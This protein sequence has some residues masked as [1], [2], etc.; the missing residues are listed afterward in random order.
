MTNTIDSLIGKIPLDSELI[1][2]GECIERIIDHRG[3]TPL[4]LGSDWKNS[5]IPAI[6]AKN[7]HGGK[8][9]NINDL[10]FVDEPTY[11]KWMGD[12]DV[13]YGDCFLVSEGATL[14]EYL[15]WKENYPV[16]LSQRVFCIRTNPEILDPKYFYAF[17]Q[18]PG[19]QNQIEGLSSGTTVMG[20]RQT[21]LLKFLVP[22]PKIK[23]QRII[24]EFILN[25]EDKIDLLHRQNQTLE[26]MAETLFRQWFIEEAK[27]EWDY[28]SLANYITIYNG[29]SYKSTDLNPSKIAMVTL[30]SF[31]RNGGFRLDGF[32]EYTGKYKEQHVVYEGDLVVAHTD[33]TQDAALIGNPVLVIGRSEYETLIISMDLVKVESN[34]EWLSKVFLYFLM[35]TRSFKEHCVGYS[36]GST[37]LHLSKDAVPSYEFL[38]PPTDQIIEF[39]SV[40]NP[41]I[42]KINQ[43][44][45]HIRN[46]E[47]QRDTLLPKL[48]SGEVRVKLN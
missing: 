1:E 5:G 22:I 11:K 21:A 39:T 40:V 19:F 41:M 7:I 29:V 30:K 27:E 18:S 43:N 8:L 42:Q 3:K 25:I 20:L 23:S 31:A 12:I 10:R 32:K 37:V 35:R 44:I 47:Q 15:M 4:K 13:Q 9:T 46:L 14:G 24:G 34:Y 2:L 28:V 48:M 33:I 17:V 16:V 36:N 45:S 6:S 38:I 26:Q